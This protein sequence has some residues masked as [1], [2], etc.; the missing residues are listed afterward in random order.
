MQPVTKIVQSEEEREALL[1]AALPP[2]PPPAPEPEPEP[3]KKVPFYQDFFSKMAGSAAA[4]LP[5]SDG[6]GLKNRKGFRGGVNKPK[7]KPPKRTIWK[8]PPGWEPPSRPP[9]PPAPTVVSWYDAG[10]RL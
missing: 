3:P 5:V 7:P 4:R 2:A 10:K 1:A 6:Y 9:P 8:P